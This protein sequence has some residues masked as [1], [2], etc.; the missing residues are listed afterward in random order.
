M[1]LTKRR[2]GGGIDYRVIYT[3]PDGQLHWQAVFVPDGTPSAEIARRLRRLRQIVREQSGGLVVGRDFAAD[4]ERLRDL[5]AVIHRDGGHY[6]AEH[7]VEKSA[8]DAAERVLALFQ[9]IE[10][11]QGEQSP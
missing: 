5:L 9:A 7:G 3:R 1:K 8:A 11:V 6:T 2:I 10:S 4:S